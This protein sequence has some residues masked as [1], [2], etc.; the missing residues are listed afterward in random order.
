MK[1]EISQADELLQLSEEGWQLPKIILPNE[2]HKVETQA[3]SLWSTTSGNFHLSHLIPHN[4]ANDL[5]LKKL[6]G[7][8]FQEP[9]SRDSTMSVHDSYKVHKISVVFT[10]I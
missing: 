9:Q 2:E 8:V 6:A 1:F 10:Y 4:R 5:I 7:S 3:T